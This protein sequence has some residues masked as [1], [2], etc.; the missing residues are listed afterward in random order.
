MIFRLW[1]RGSIFRSAHSFSQTDTPAIA[2]L[3]RNLTLSLFSTIRHVYYVCWSKIDPDS[4]FGYE[5]FSFL[6][7]GLQYPRYV[8][9]YSTVH[10]CRLDYLS[11]FVI[12]LLVLIAG[13]D[14]RLKYSSFCCNHVRRA[15]RNILNDWL[16]RRLISQRT[17][18]LVLRGW[19]ARGTHGMNLGSLIADRALGEACE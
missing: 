15:V 2:V 8:V 7:A 6:V 12:A 5:I 3:K 9:Q 18:V 11:W 1:S 10:Y 14:W 17:F 19:L 13:D 4:D 16:T